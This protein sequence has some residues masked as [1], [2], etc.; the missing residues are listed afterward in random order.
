MQSPRKATLYKT[1]SKLNLTTKELE[2]KGKVREKNQ[3]Q[4]KIQYHQIKSNH[5]LLN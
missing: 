5:K 2:E 1:S 4:K 3:Q